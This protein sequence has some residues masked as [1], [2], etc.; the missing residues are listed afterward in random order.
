V[1]ISFL[2]LI[3]LLSTAIAPV[4]SLWQT[5]AW[6]LVKLFEKSIWS[7]FAMAQAN[8]FADWSKLMSTGDAKWDAWL[9]IAVIPIIMNAFMFFMFS[10]ISRLKL[11]CFAP[12]YTQKIDRMRREHEI[13]LSSSKV[14]NANADLD[15]SLN[16]SAH[17]A[18][19][20][21]FNKAE[22]FKVGVVFMLMVNLSLLVIAG[23]FL[24]YQGALESVWILFLSM[25]V[26]PFTCSVLAIYAFAHIIDRRVHLCGC[27][28]RGDA[29]AQNGADSR[30]RGSIN[31][32]TGVFM[33]LDEL[34]HVPMTITTNTAND[35]RAGY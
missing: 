24:G 1:S 5:T 15:E 7:L 14:R 8:V 31:N 34:S 21:S 10:R 25:I 12:K 23:G 30:I 26:A 17:G 33:D 20:V 3:F 6:V 19:S 18:V 11:P 4:S 22:A 32:G 28:Q 16:A 27:G 9:Y 35:G 29:S 13:S 2:A